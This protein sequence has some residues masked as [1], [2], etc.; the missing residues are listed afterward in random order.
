SMYF[1]AVSSPGASD[2]AI[3]VGHR[4]DV[5]AA[6]NRPPDDEK[7]QP[8]SDSP[9]TAAA[10]RSTVRSAKWRP[11]TIRP[12]GSDP[13]GWQGTLTAGWP[14]TLNGAVFGTISKARPTI[15]SRGAP[16]AGSGVGR[17]GWVGSTSTSTSS[18]APS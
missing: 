5:H 17:S 4:D 15:S 12:I 6:R 14:V 3:L 16:G 9:S 2:D 10:T 7:F 11:T 18:R 8:M 1:T 13:G